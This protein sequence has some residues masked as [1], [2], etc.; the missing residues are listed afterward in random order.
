MQK[1]TRETEV[2]LIVLLF[3]FLLTAFTVFKI[4]PPEPKVRIKSD[5]IDVTPA[6]TTVPVPELLPAE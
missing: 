3:M 2:F 6:K 5:W 1:T 4:M